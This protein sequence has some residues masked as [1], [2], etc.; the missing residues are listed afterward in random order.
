MSL[1]MYQSTERG[2]LADSAKTAQRAEFRKLVIHVL[3]RLADDAY[4]G[5]GVIPQGMPA[6]ETDAIPASWVEHALDSYEPM[7]NLQGAEDELG[8]LLSSLHSASLRGGAGAVVSQANANRA[9]AALSY[10]RGEVKSR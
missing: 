2:N 6:S 10:L 9:R 1:C 4:Q 7:L 8:P 5:G 3:T